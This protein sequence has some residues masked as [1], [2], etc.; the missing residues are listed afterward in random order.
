MEQEMKAMTKNQ[1]TVASIIL[2]YRKA[3]ESLERI[4]SERFY[5]GIDVIVND[6]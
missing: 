5:H 3:V 2:I 4:K 6:P 1:T